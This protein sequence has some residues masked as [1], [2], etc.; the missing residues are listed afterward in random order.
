[1]LLHDVLGRLYCSEDC[2]KYNDIPFPFNYKNKP[3]GHQP[4]DINLFFGTLTP[5]DREKLETDEDLMHRL[6]GK[7]KRAQ[8]VCF[9]LFCSGLFT[10]A[11][12]S[13]YFSTSGVSL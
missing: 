13:C 12:C 10:S 7:E 6:A 3:E 4:K 5:R 8:V 11:P 2:S 1:M 9:P